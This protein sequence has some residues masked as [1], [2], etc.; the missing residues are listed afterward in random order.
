[1]LQLQ[2]QQTAEKAGGDLIFMSAKKGAV[3][4]HFALVHGARKEVMAKVLKSL[5]PSV[6]EIISQ[7]DVEDAF[8]EAAK[9][10]DDFELMIGIQHSSAFCEKCGNCCRLCS[11]IVLDPLD[12]NTLGAILGTDRLVH[13]VTFKDGKWHFRKTK[14]CAFLRENKC[15]IYAFRPL[16]CRQFP[17]VEKDGVLTLGWFSYCKFPVNML[18]FRTTGLIMKRVVEKTDPLLYARMEK[19]GQVLAEGLKLMRSQKDR[20]VFARDLLNH[21]SQGEKDKYVS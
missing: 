21:L 16:V 20:L 7:S 14:P 5:K 9:G 15:I 19:Q 3:R 1:V 12:I 4:E 18:A 2:S 11:P 10:L 6:F 17:F 13:Y 8:D